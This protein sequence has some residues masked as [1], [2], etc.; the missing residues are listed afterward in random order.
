M[1][2]TSI[3]KNRANPQQRAARNATRTQTALKDV[4]SSR[5]QSQGTKRPLAMDDVI[6]GERRGPPRKPQEKIFKISQKLE[7][8]LVDASQHAAPRRSP[9]PAVGDV[10]HSGLPIRYAPTPAYSGAGG[11]SF[12]GSSPFRLPQLAMIAM[13]ILALLWIGILF[14]APVKTNLSGWTGSALESSVA[15][16]LPQAQ[17]LPQL[18]TPLGQHSL[19]TA[20]SVSAAQI[21]KVL[22]QFNSPAAGTGE[23]WVKL[24]EQY[25]IDP[26]YAL[27]FFIHESSAGTNPNWAGLKGGGA[28]THN[29]GNIICAGYATCYGR[30]R[31]YPDWQSGIAD[32]YRLIRDE[33][34]QGRGTHTL[35]QII[36]I[37]APSVEN[38]V[39]AYVQAVT[40]L[41]DSWK[42]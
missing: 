22:A 18:A 11:S 7:Q 21:N 42:H 30:F 14:F 12:A 16:A 1:T 32:W 38:N 40:N 28:T 10:Y 31:D 27:A 26:A 36:P 3:S 35:E 13:A 2:D 17:P 24:G 29:V 4:H 34:V 33:Y 20:P 19:V 9:L 15:Q 25:Q 23:M 5:A 8:D 39:P 6:A 37:Y 41:I